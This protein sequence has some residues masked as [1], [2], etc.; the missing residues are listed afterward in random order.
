MAD[1]TTDPS[2]F[3]RRREQVLDAL[4]SDEAMLLTAAPEIM[5]GRDMELRYVVDPDLWYLTGYPEPEA[6]ALLTRAADSA[7]TLFVRPRDPEREVWTGPRGGIEAA[8][9]R[10]R[11]DEAYP[12]A[13]LPAR[14]PDL[15][16][17]T[18]RIHFRLGGGRADVERAVLDL[19]GRSR[20]RRQRSGVGPTELVDP[21]LFLD[22]MRLVKD[23]GEI[24]AI[25]DA[26]DITVAAFRKGL[27]AVRPGAGEWEVE[28]A[29]EGA[30][31]HAGADGPAFATIAASGPNATVL[32]YTANRRRMEAGDLLL[33]DAGARHRIYNGDLSRTVPVGGHFSGP[34]RDLYQAVLAA[35][36]AAIAAATP[37]A[38]VHD[39]HRAALQV[40]ARAMVE[41]GLL[42][43]DAD[44]LMDK[45]DLIRQWYPHN[46][47]H[48]L[49]L[50][51]HDVGTYRVNG[52]PRRL[53]PGMVL[54]IEPGLYVPPHRDDAPP[55]LRGIGV[56]I[57]DDIVI[58]ATGADVL[59]AALPTG[60]DEIEQLVRS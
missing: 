44:E 11:A 51:V 59:S 60:I 30:M 21:G 40:L 3:A 16:G 26:V 38:T 4:G 45:D 27:A 9:D 10:Y 50:D 49:G 56:R 47:S 5:V 8:R 1:P 57:E 23:P 14:L 22:E 7:F 20:A 53:E 43:G 25:R 31:R 55:H 18:R 13:E 2:V 33:L 42:Q 48:W 19:L 34:Q 54:T 28:A 52:T 29:V 39:V 41:L 6:V 12:I 36:H 17:Q 24:E 15:I 32:H 46:T 37:G 35:E 58:T